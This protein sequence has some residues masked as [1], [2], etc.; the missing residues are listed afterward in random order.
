MR[1]RRGAR[2]TGGDAAAPRVVFDTNTVVSALLFAN[3]RLAWL[4]QHWSTG[5][6]VALISRATAGEITRVLSYPKFR[7]APQDRVELL[8][9]YLPFCETVERVERCEWVCRDRND[10]PFLDLAASG[11]A[12]VLVTGDRDLLA[13][14][15]ET[16]FSIETPEAYLGRICESGQSH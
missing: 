11:R 14:A 2:R 15:G 16:P 9:D 13:L 12:A 7:L 5:G 3:G 1:Q 6:S 4:R 8:G 10:Q